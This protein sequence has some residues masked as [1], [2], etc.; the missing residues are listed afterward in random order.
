M[1]TSWRAVAGALPDY[2]E[3]LADTTRR[4]TMRGTSS[5]L[6]YLQ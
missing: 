1:R 3:Q 5:E 2:G 6:R 4:T